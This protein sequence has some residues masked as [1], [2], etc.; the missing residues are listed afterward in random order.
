MTDLGQVQRKKIYELIGTLGRMGQF[1]HDKV[2]CS[3]LCQD[4][5]MIFWPQASL[6]LPL[7]E[8]L[9]GA[10]DSVHKWAVHMG[11]PLKNFRPEL[12]ISSL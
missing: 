7:K 9:M 11:N 2:I 3:F 4:T 10:K 12:L 1:L 8:W 5:W 6:F